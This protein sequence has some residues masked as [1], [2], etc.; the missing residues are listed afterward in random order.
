MS[1]IIL[2]LAVLTLLVMTTSPAD[3]HSVYMDRTLFAQS[4]DNGSA[5]SIRA[6][7]AD[8]PDRQQQIDAGCSVSFV[9]IDVRTDTL[10]DHPTEPADLVRVSAAVRQFDF[11]PPGP[12]P[13]HS[14]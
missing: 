12:P 14:F 6:E 7:S 5:V 2:C 11:Y 10:R 4:A 1:R 9:L 13:R 3:A 8:F